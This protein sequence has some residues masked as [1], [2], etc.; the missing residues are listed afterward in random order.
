M[1]LEGNAFYVGTLRIDVELGSSS[2]ISI[3]TG[4]NHIEILDDLTMEKQL[5]MDRNPSL[6][7]SEIRNT[8]MTEIPGKPPTF[9]SAPPPKNKKAFVLPDPPFLWWRTFILF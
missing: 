7:S 9:E 5:L 2:G 6:A 3:I 1:P 8:L 4:I